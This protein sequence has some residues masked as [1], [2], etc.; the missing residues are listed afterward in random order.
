MSARERTERALLAMCIAAPAEGREFI[1]RLTPEH[2]SSPLV[3]RARDWLA[4]HLDDPLE[5]LPREDEEL[6]SL[7]TQLVMSAERE[8]GG[9]EAMELNFL[10]LEQAAIEG[11]IDGGA[12]RGGRPSG[13]ASSAAAPSS[14]SA[15]PTARRPG[16]ADLPFTPLKATITANIRSL[17]RP[18]RRA[19]FVHG[20]GSLERYLAEGLSLRQIGRLDGS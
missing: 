4:E 9:R 2:L 15:S 18:T 10:Q 11:R 7:V 12:A 5:G 14:L 3:A 16:P 1:G 8:P 13:R 6:V 17:F 20:S 19:E